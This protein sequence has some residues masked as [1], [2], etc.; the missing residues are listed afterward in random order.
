LELK[1]LGDIVVEISINLNFKE[2]MVKMLRKFQT[3]IEMKGEI[4][5]NEQK[6]EKK[7]LETLQKAKCGNKDALM[8]LI[9]KFK[10]IIRKYSRK[11]RYDT[12]E[13]DLVI[14]LIKI[15]KIIPIDRESLNNDNEFVS[16]IAAAIRYEY[17]KLRK[18]NSY[19]EIPLNDFIVI[20]CRQIDHDLRICINQLVDKLPSKEKFIINSIFFYGYSE[21]ELAKKLDISRQAVNKTKN[22]A[23]RKLLTFINN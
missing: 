11:L 15:I 2:E 18:Q 13:S 4:L 5:M 16:Y 12:A 19:Q 1:A 17:Y 21:A 7:M 10:P 9:E 22:N 3:N 20:D 6:M 8:E 23:L 14:E